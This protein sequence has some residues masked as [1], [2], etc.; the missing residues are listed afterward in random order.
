MDPW[1]IALPFATPASSRQG[2]KEPRNDDDD[3]YDDD[4]S[5]GASP[6]Q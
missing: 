5:V 2:T 1:R 3:G 6:T 4:Q